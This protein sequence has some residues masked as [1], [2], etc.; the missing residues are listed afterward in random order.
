M[1]HYAG[2]E[3]IYDSLED[4]SYI[5]SNI[6][7]YPILNGALS[8]WNDLPIQDNQAQIAIK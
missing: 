6:D 4:L 5:L 8:L 3:N 2:D 7:A 1:A